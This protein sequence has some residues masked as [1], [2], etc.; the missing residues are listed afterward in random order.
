MKKRTLYTDQALID[1][2]PWHAI[3]Y[4]GG[5]NIL[6]FFQKPLIFL[7][8]Y[9]TFVYLCATNNQQSNKIYNLKQKF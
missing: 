5:R 1:I 9:K 8:F 6:I 4:G 7:Y 3:I 2:T